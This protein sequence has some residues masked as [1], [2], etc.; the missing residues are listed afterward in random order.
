MFAEE[1]QT[2]Q[3]TSDPL[4]HPATQR[5]G[6]EVPREAVLVYSRESRVLCTAE[7][8]RDSSQDLVPEPASQD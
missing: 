1:A 7:A 2:Q 3:K 8:H 6:E 4:H 5:P